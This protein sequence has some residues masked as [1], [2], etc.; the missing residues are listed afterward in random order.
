MDIPILVCGYDGSN[1]F[2]WIIYFNKLL[3]IQN[4]VLEG[5]LLISF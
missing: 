5:L 1:E 4:K 2:W 3:I